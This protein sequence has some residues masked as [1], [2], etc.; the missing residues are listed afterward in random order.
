MAWKLTGDLERYLAA[1]GEQIRARPVI[2]TVELTVL[3]TLRA[4]GS[5]TYGDSPPV[6][7]WHEPPAGPAD[8]AF[9]QTPPYPLLLTA[10]PPG[11]AADLVSTLRAH[12][13]EVP[14]VNAAEDD[15]AEFATA[16]S[17]AAGRVPEVFQRTRLFR[18]AG[19]RPPKPPPGSARAAREADRELLE[20]WLRA[21]GAEAGALGGTS[22]VAETVSDRLSYGGLMLWES[23]SRPVSMAG[24]TRQV[25]GVTRIGPV[26]TPPELRGRGYG[27]AITAAVSQ[28]AL[29]RGAADVVLFTDLANPV[30]N[31]LY[32]RLGYRAVED[33]VVLTFRS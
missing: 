14:G 4:C 11:S 19:L 28:A 17:A 30:S 29:G 16:W 12:G 24:L 21:F 22:R 27:G 10:L 7:G 32:Q 20:S 1:F 8:G 31:A 3:E 13:A 23:G 26:Y 2:H 5:H 18:L 6:F 9:L 33:R 25:A 15:A